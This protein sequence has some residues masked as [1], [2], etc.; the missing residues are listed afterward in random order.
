M[1]LTH[2]V[3]LFIVNDINYWAIIREISYV[4]A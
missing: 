1:L 2:K 3:V 4:K